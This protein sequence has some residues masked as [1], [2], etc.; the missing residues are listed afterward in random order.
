[1]E[2]GHP[3][4]HERV[5]ANERFLGLMVAV[6]VKLSVLR[7]LADKDVRAPDALE[8]LI[9]PVGQLLR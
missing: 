9:Q 8:D 5:S 1:M 6:E 3:C 2:R 7:T 4:P